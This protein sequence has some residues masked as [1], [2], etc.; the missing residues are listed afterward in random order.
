MLIG[1]AVDSIFVKLL[2]WNMVSS[3]ILYQLLSRV[4]EI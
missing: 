1:L 3:Y 2:V 4:A